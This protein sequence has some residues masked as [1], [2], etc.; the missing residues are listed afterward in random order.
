[1]L[2]KRLERSRLRRWEIRDRWGDEL[3]RV[4]MECRGELNNEGICHGNQP[5]QW[6][7]LSIQQPQRLGL[8][9]WTGWVSL[10]EWE[11]DMD[12]N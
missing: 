3:G 1:M 4:V 7:R 12:A 10:R 9:G 2:K 6:Q 8:S 5:V 11:R